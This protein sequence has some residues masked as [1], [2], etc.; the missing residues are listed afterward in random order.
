MSN[1]PKI[2]PEVQ[3]VEDELQD[4]FKH[5]YT[6]GTPITKPALFAGRQQAL[7]T[8]RQTRAAGMSYVIQGPVGLGKTSLAH[9][10]FAGK[11]AFW[12]TASE[13]TDFVSIF[14]AALL[15]IGASMTEAER[16]ELVK[17]GVSV[18]VKPIGTTAEV[19][20]ELNVKKVQVAAQKL[21]LNFVL[22]RVVKHE[23]NIDSIVIDEFQRVKDTKIHTQVVEVIKGLADRSSNVAVV[24]VGITAQGKELVTDPDFP[25]Y[26]GRHVTAIRLGPM[27]ESE[28]L[29]IFQRRQE[30]FNVAFPPEAQQK[31]SWISCGYPH[32]VHK[33][34]LQS[35]FSWLFRSTVKIVSDMVLSWIRR[36]VFRQ[37]KIHA[38][39]VKTLSVSVEISDMIY[40]V[41]SFVSEYE[42][43]HPLA[44][45][46]LRELEQKERERLLSG[47]ADRIGIDGQYFPSYARAKDYLNAIGDT[48]TATADRRSV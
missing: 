40:A 24:L 46:K 26:L 28:A 13:D 2:A 41:R 34:A 30:F 35:C 36:N 3:A 5:V 10:L 27:T 4:Q 17:A 39:D 15:A 48:G 32:L 47:R 38:P 14:L 8:V 25:R 37:K 9:Q 6:P 45:E 43:N 29:E 33:L 23:R 42:D 31:I 11:R 18:S 44:A 19:G 1:R 22:D 12:H 16:T 20:T 7:K 21:D